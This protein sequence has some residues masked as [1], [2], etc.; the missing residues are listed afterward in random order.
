MVGLFA[1]RFEQSLARAGI[2]CDQRLTLIERLRCDFACMID[3]HERGHL[4]SLRICHRFRNLLR[5]VGTRAV[6][7]A[8]QRPQGLIGRLDQPVQE[9]KHPRFE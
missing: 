9:G 3:A 5:R 7:G 6:G 4:G 2:A 8:K 1:A